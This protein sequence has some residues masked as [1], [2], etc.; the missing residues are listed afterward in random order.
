MVIDGHLFSSFSSFSFPFPFPFLF[1]FSFRLL[2]SFLFSSSFL[3]FPFSSP[4]PFPLIPPFPFP[5]P[6]FPFPFPTPLPKKK[7]PKKKTKKEKTYPQ[8]RPRPHIQHHLRLLYGS[9]MQFPIQ[10]QQKNM[11][12]NI[13]LIILI[14]II[15]S[16]IFFFIGRIPSTVFV[17]ES[18]D[19]GCE[20]CCF[21]FS[22]ERLGGESEVGRGDGGRTLRILL[23]RR[24]SRCLLLLLLLLLRGFRA[25]GMERRL[26]SGGLER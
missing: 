3:F 5:S 13:Q 12:S 2:F 8:P 18:G 15:R 21:A 22:D 9:Q 20:G 1:S 11:M 10:Q 19:G 24:R 6:F 7:K 14:F 23:L 17:A 26:V 25:G 4:F 16:P